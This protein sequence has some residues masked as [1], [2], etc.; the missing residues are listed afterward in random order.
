MRTRR[1][2]SRSASTSG[3]GSSPRRTS[4]ALP[5]LAEDLRRGN[6]RAEAA[7][8]SGELQHVAHF[9]DAETSRFPR[10]RIANVNPLVQPAQANGLL[11]NRRQEENLRLAA[12]G[13][14][15]KGV[16]RQAGGEDAGNV[17]DGH[18]PHHATLLRRVPEPD[19]RPTVQ[20]AANRY[21]PPEIRVGL[22]EQRP[23][24]LR[25]AGAWPSSRARAASAAAPTRVAARR[26]RSE[27]EIRRLRHAQRGKDLQGEN[28]HLRAGAGENSQHRPG[29]IGAHLH[30]RRLRGSVLRLTLGVGQ[31][32][33]QRLDA[34]DPRLPQSG[35]CLGAGV[36]RR[37]AKFLDQLGQP[38]RVLDR[39]RVGGQDRAG[40]LTG[41]RI[42]L[43]DVA[44][45]R[46]VFSLNC[47]ASSASCASL[48]L[49]SR[50]S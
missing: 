11:Q 2:G 12:V 28:L 40:Q 25:W 43:R 10:G 39:L 19:R 5:I 20:L 37:V 26:I 1:S 18:R 14:N 46:N 9:R 24:R 27:D 38:F 47:R 34:G 48:G 44:K 15:G 30:Q 21:P 13:R 3:V 17:L 49:A 7:L 35:D 41:R 31:H 16:L 4:S 6:R 23:R 33:D 32:G 45:S 50:T 22:L 42:Q 36:G 29:R 8:A